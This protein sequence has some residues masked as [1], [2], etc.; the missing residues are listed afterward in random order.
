MV[1]TNFRIVAVDNEMINQ[2]V[3]CSG[4][5]S[6]WFLELADMIKPGNTDYWKTIIEDLKA[7]IASFIFMIDPFYYIGEEFSLK[8]IKPGIHLTKLELHLQVPTNDNKGL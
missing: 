3:V 4:I 2:Q 1:Y 5:I 6:E 8:S 7:D